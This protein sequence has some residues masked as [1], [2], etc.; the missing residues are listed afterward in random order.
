MINVENM[1]DSLAFNYNINKNKKKLF[2]QKIRMYNYIQN[3]INENFRN[4][5]Y[6]KIHIDF[7][8]LVFNETFY[9]DYNNFVYDGVIFVDLPLRY[10]FKEDDYE[11][12]DY[13]EYDYDENDN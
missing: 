11:E 1:G 13:E 10:K 4:N 7:N 5:D 12:Y 9:K 8:D 3:Y 2:N 6:T